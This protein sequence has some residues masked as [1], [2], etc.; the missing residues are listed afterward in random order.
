M[1]EQAR[2]LPFE[3]V[4]VFAE[5]PFSGNPLAVVYEADGLA[6]GQLQAIARE[7]NLSE[8]VFPL[9]ASSPGADYRARIFTPTVELPFAG[10]PSVG[11]AWSLARSGVLGSAEAVQECGAGLLPVRVDADGA[12]VTGGSPSVGPALDAV[13]LAHALALAA[14]DVDRALPAGVAA[15]GLDYAILPVRAGAV[16]RARVPATLAEPGKL[17]VCAV[18]PDG[19]EVHA[20]VFAPSV[21]VPE[22]P[23]TG[24][25]A[26]A[27]GVFLVDRGVLAGD[28]R[29]AF[30]IRQGAEVGRPSVLR[31]EVGAAGGAAERV[32]VGGPV[33]AV[34]R[35]EIAVPPEPAG[36]PLG[37]SRG[38]TPGRDEAGRA[39]GDEPAG[40]RIGS[41]RRVRRA[42]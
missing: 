25:A 19:A 15:A 11:V 38:T 31:V 22:D 26:V 24:S 39:I 5:R 7:F 30:T 18:S 8:T 29:S 41:P 16:A 35:G 13:A 33:V 2:M 9:P 4:D 10:H 1:P 6:T 40:V 28:A 32:S 17:L 21:G 34:A 42:E 14:D 36:P 37:G 12:W 20:R 27:L 3:V 23:A